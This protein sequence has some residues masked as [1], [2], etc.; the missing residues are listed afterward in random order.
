MPAKSPPKAF[1]ATI[2]QAALFFVHAELPQEDC[3]SVL[4]EASR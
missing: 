3:N 2:G 1:R 4:N